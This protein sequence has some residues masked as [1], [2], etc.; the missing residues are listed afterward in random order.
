MHPWPA[1][2]V[3]LR[4]HRPQPVSRSLRA[5]HR[6][7]GG[8]FPRVHGSAHPRRRP[9]RL[10]A[11][12]P[13]LARS[14]SRGRRSVCDG[15]VRRGRDGGCGDQHHP[16]WRSTGVEVFRMV[17]SLFGASP[18]GCVAGPC[19]GDRRR[20]DRRSGHR[21]Q[22]LE[23][24]HAVGFIWGRLNHNRV[25]GILKNPSYAGTYV[26]GRS[27]SA[28]EISPDGG[29]R[30]RTRCVPLDAWLVRI[31]TMATSAGR[32]SSGT[33]SSWRTTAPTPSTCP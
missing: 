26:F 23:A 10:P 21:G 4:R 2:N 17:V 28:K 22:G 16:G 11:A 32:S 27:R 30:T 12:L 5:A 9:A 24:L 14:A 15:L 3:A 7:P 6:P 25:L 33:N 19:V 18:R 20:G 1:I 8:S 31:T 29:V 13:A